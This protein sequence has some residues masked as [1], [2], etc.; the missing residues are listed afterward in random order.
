[1]KRTP[2]L[3]VVM[4]G[5]GMA[6]EDY[7]AEM[8]AIRQ[9]KTPFFD[10]LWAEHPHAS[11]RCSGHAVGL[12]D[13]VMGNVGHLNLGAGRVVWQDITR[14]D[15][16]IQQ[17]GLRSNRAFVGAIDRAIQSGSRLHLM[18][19][20]SDGA[21]HSVDRHYFALLR[22][23]KSAGLPA[24]RVFFHCYMDGRDTAPQSGI[25]YIRQLLKAMNEE[26]LGRIA[27]VSGRYYAMDRDRRWDRVRKAYEALVCGIGVRA[28]SA[29]QAVLSFYAEDARGDEFII[30]RIIAGEG[31]EPVGR[32]RSGDEVIFFNYRA[33]R[34]REMSHALV[35]A[36]FSGFER[37]ERVDI[38]LTT[39]TEYEVGLKADVA[40]P[41][42]NLT[43]T[44]GEIASRAGLKQLRI[45]ETEKY[46]H[47]TYFFSGG[48]EKPFDGED[49]I[50]VPSPKVATYDMQPEMS[51]PEVA[52][53]LEEA[54]RSGQYD[55]IVCNFANCDM[56]GHT[57]V[58]KAAIQAA[59]TVDQ[60]LSR[61]VPAVLDLSGVALLTADHGNA[62]QMWNYVDN[63]PDTQHTTG[64]PTPVVLVG[65]KVKGAR[66]RADGALCDVAPTLWTLMGQTLP[67]EMAGRS[68]VA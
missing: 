48:R 27:T 8:N 62:E 63:C 41:P 14:I 36:D 26:G 45:A 20:V 59:E 42:H 57:G 53:R 65:A 19:L 33:D 50:L 11:L 47:V 58:L 35:D 52:R 66:L 7:P 18:G 15:R 67:P 24:E 21:V 22:L 37:R 60:A 17:D 31:G 68:L 38:R 51:A 40:F 4:D 13:G 61:V 25:G 6:P 55:L 64:N 49:R 5:W 54:I 39:M 28:E 10:R 32:I 46:A 44:L 3:L 2:H 56:V 43:N 9:A 29:E 30:P 1:M 12:P 23:A 34:T 16:A